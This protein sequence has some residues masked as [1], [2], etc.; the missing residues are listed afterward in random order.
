[1]MDFCGCGCGGCWWAFADWSKPG[2]DQGTNLAHVCREAVEEMKKD[3]LARKGFKP[4][5]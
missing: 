4:S 5:D 3:H 1:M 2:A